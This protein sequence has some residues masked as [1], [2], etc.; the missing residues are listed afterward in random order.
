VELR[1][2]EHL[3]LTEDRQDKNKDFLENLNPNSLKICNAKAE[4]MLQ[5]VKPEQHFQFLRKGY[6]VSDKDSTD[7]LKVFNEAVSLKDGFKKKR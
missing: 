1:K 7:K 5:D 3:F 4:P 6:Y 2:F